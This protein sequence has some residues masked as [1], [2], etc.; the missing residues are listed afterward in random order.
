MWDGPEQPIPT[1]RTQRPGDLWIVFLIL[2]VLIVLFGAFVTWA[3]F[4]VAADAHAAD[5]VVVRV[6]H[7]SGG[8]F[9]PVVRFTTDTGQI[10]E[11][12]A[13]AEMTK[14]L[15]YRV[16]QTVP[17]WYEPDHPENAT[18]D[19]WDN[20]WGLGFFLGLLGLVVC[21][22][23]VGLHRNRV[24]QY[25]LAEATA[26]LAPG[27][28]VRHAA[29]AMRGPRLA[30]LGIPLGVLVLLMLLADPWGDG[31]AL[32]AFIVGLLCIAAIPVVW[33]EVRVLLTDRRL[34][35]LRGYSGNSVVVEI[36]IDRIRVLGES[37]GIGL[38]F[39]AASTDSSVRPVRLTF[40]G[41]TSLKGGSPLYRGLTALAAGRQ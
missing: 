15:R 19:T 27:E 39:V 32:A 22:A 10:V 4:L 13:E 17:L 18:F 36:P 2:G 11:F 7:E 5:G 25:G 12:I 24:G 40:T 34:I 35:V 20:R 41:V 33:R 14:D 26:W 38:T 37:E 16:G 30:L 3:T 31:F 28:H 1:G 23:A 6:V 29:I 21:L 9:T 8:P